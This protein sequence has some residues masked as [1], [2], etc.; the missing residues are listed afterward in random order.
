MFKVL[1]SDKDI[2]VVIKPCGY[3]SED[4][5]SG[6]V[7]ALIR[8][9]LAVK[10]V[11][12]VHR[13]DRDVSGIMVYALNGAA[14]AALT[15]AMLENEFEKVYLAIVHGMPK[16]PCGSMVDLLFKDSKKNKSYVVKRERKGVR[17]AE[18]EYR[19]LESK[20]GLSLV[21]VK[22][23]TGRSHQIRVQFASRRMPLYGDRKYGAP[24]AKSKIAL[25]SHML[26]FKHPN[27]EKMTFS[28]FPFGETW[29]KF[30]FES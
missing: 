29:D 13:L 18:L 5:E 24:S 2:A 30:D 8:E 3:L 12:T 19:L 4:A 14:A 28:A 16:E 20:D 11:F 23:C 22:L 21:R 10:D 25:F 15:R 1:Y 7:C 26:T 27:G 17:R 9:A 6:S